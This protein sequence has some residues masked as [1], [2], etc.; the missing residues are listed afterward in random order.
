MFSAS[1]VVKRIS[2]ELRM[3]TGP[4]GKQPQKSRAASN[5]V[6]DVKTKVNLMMN[7]CDNFLQFSSKFAVTR[8]TR[9][10]TLH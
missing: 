7:T 4:T 10:S 9:L 3:S 2:P 6:E 5:S 8:T 1:G